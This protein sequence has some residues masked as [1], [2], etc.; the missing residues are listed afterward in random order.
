MSVGSLRPHIPMKASPYDRCMAGL[1]ASIAIMG[2]ISFGLF[3]VW[4]SGPADSYHLP[5]LP[6]KDIP[7]VV[8]APEDGQD[9]VPSVIEFPELQ[10]NTM[11]FKEIVAVTDQVSAVLAE[12]GDSFGVGEHDPREPI[13]QP[14]T[15]GGGSVNQWQIDFSVDGLNEYKQIID[16]FAIELGV[17]HSKRDRI[18]RVSN[19][20]GVAHVVESNR[21]RESKSVYFSNRTPLLRSWDRAIAKDAV[22]ELEEKPIVVLFYSPELVAH[23]KQLE[24]DYLSRV[25]RKRENVVHTSFRIESNG[26]NYQFVVDKCEY[27][28]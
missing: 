1:T 23:L 2:S 7:D 14:R 10:A 21:K 8:V 18:R 26:E 20:S 12:H 17:V 11:L 24:T 5:P 15:P 13:P 22:G 19:V 6:P 4:L 16:Q 3:I 28:Y 9:L 27:R 25:N